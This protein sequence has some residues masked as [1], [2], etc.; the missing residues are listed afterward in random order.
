M[1]LTRDDALSAQDALSEGE[2]AS[3][4]ARCPEGQRKAF[5]G[6]LRGERHLDGDLIER[7]DEDRDARHDRGGA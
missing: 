5:E 4:V 1:A 2:I 3:L 6:W 7:G